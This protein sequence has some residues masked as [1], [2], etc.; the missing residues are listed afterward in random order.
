MNDADKNAYLDQMRSKIQKLTKYLDFQPRYY[1][2]YSHNDINNLINQ[3]S[4]TLFGD[5]ATFQTNNIINNNNNTLDQQSISRNSEDHFLNNN[6]KINT[7]MS[8]K[9]S[10]YQLEVDSAEVD[11]DPTINNDYN[12]VLKTPLQNINKIELKNLYIPE[13]KITTTRNNNKFS[14]YIDQS[15]IDIIVVEGLHDI[16][17]IINDIN[18]K[19][20]DKIK[21]S[22]DDGYVMIK[23]T[24]P[25][26]HISL[27]PQKL[28]IFKLLGFTKGDYNGSNY[29]KAE[30]KHQFISNQK[31]IFN[32][33]DIISCE[34]RAKNDI[35]IKDHLNINMLDT[36]YVSLCDINNNPIYFDK[37]QH[38]QFKLIIYHN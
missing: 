24:D 38:H 28:S 11:Y 22:I 29:Y 10:E 34:Y 14:C 18:Q 3:M 9:T 37:N 20:N 7:G 12:I 27:L 4:F 5:A 31:V 17:D 19:S 2:G 15:E 25:I 33:R 21:L 13:S 16:N 23:S 36:I 6:T 32:I 1:V 8:N 30:I 35:I 26:H